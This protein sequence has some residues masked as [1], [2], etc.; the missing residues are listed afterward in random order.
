MEKSQAIETNGQG[1]EK[2]AVRGAVK[3]AFCSEDF[4][5]VGTLP[6]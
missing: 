1:F 6:C 4:I 5:L 3:V 2:Y